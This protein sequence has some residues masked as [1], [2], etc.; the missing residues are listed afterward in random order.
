MKIVNYGEK[1]PKNLILALGYFDAVHVGHKAVL[2]KTVAIAKSKNLSPTALIFTGGKSDCDVFSLAE[3]F[4]RIF[5]LQIE[6][7]IVKSLDRA[8]MQKTKTEFL[9]EITSLY[10]IKGVVSGSD[11]TFG[12]NAEGSVQTLIDFFGQDRVFTEQL[13]GDGT[14]KFSSSNVKQ[15]LLQGD[16]KRANFYLGDEYFIKGEVLRGKGL[17]KT[18]GFP[19]ANVK[20]EDS[21]L[22]IKQGVYKTFVL[23]GGKR[24]GAIS[25][26]G[27]QPTVNGESVILETYISG[28][29]GDLYGKVLTVYFEDYIRDIK[30]F[31][32]LEELSNQLIKDK[33]V[34]ND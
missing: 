14:E 27:A 11:F 34:L 5:K 8:F 16:I 32:S 7:I 28:F 31:S 13:L 22:K 15:A 10:D 18:L 12:L 19:T 17:G 3:R 6:N 1:L 4:D 23:I 29:N 9:T 20:I 2:N 30:K 24:Y 33:G 21:K 25:N 26:F